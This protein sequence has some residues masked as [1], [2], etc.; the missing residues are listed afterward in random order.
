MDSRVS[1]SDALGKI[2]AASPRLVPASG[3][4]RGVGAVCCTYS[5]RPGLARDLPRRYKQNRYCLGALL[6]DLNEPWKVIAR[7]ARPIMEP[8]EPYETTG[9]LWR[10][11]LHQRP[12]VPG[13]RTDYLL[14]CL[15]PRHLCRTFSIAEILASLTDDASE[16]K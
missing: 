7:S 16:T 10:G 2:I 13:R 1:R 5:H 12:S 8:T 6:L 4:V 15:R 14:R 9:F 11:H 3:T